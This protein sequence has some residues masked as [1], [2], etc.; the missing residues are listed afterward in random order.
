MSQDFAANP[1]MNPGNIQIFSVLLQLLEQL[2]VTEVERANSAAGFQTGPR[3]AVY[4]HTGHGFEAALNRLRT[5]WF[6]ENRQHPQKARESLLA[7]TK[8]LIDDVGEKRVR[9]YFGYNAISFENEQFLL[10]SQG[11]VTVGLDAVISAQDP[12]TRL[13][14]ADTSEDIDRISKERFA[15]APLI[16]VAEA[17]RAKDITEA[18]KVILGDMR[19]N[20]PEAEEA[21]ELLERQSEFLDNILGKVHG[22]GSEEAARKSL[23]ELLHDLIESIV[24]ALAEELPTKGVLAAAALA[25]LGVA[26]V[27]VTNFIAALVAGPIIGPELLKRIFEGRRHEKSEID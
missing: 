5:A 3:N 20:S 13:K 2:S 9:E 17:K 24:T 12:D 16:V 1:G 6:E 7:I 10:S 18:L 11:S 26:G 19:L 25:L 8:Q 27:E 23:L 4:T 14:T 15:E 21:S 22:D